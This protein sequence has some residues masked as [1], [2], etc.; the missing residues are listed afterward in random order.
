MS[1]ELPVLLAYQGPAQRNDGPDGR[2]VHMNEATYL[3][4]INALHSAPNTC[5]AHTP[6]QPITSSVHTSKQAK[7][8]FHRSSPIR[9]KPCMHSQFLHKIPCIGVRFIISDLSCRDI[10]AKPAVR[11]VPSIASFNQPHEGWGVGP[12]LIR[13]EAKLTRLEG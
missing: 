1:V 7:K 5:G 2:G 11:T 3:W 10:C 6:S 8:Y 13:R 9:A 12:W 4:V